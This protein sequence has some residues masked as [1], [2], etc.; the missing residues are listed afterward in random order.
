MTELATQPAQ[1]LA[2]PPIPL[3]F[4]DNAAAK[5]ADLIAEEGNPELKLRVFVQGGGC[6]GFQYGFTFDDAVN[7]DDT[8]FEKNGVTLLVDSMSFQYLVGAEIDYKEDINGSQFVI[9][10]PN[11]TTTC[12]CGSSFSA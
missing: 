9:K 8:L 1:D 10:N 7:E 12:G 2:E 5:V 11:A 4:T 6:S 3:V